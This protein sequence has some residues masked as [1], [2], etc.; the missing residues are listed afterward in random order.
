MGLLQESVFSLFAKYKQ[1]PCFTGGLFKAIPVICIDV[2]KMAKVLS[3]NINKTD[4]NVA[5][6]MV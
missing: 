4:K 5:R 6:L 1:S 2:R 3:I